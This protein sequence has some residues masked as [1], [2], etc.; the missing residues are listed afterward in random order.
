MD[1]A[2]RQDTESDNSGWVNDNSADPEYPGSR[3]NNTGQMWD[4]HRKF[5]DALLSYLQYG[6]GRSRSYYC[7]CSGAMA[8]WRRSIGLTIPNSVKYKRSYVQLSSLTQHCNAKN[9]VY[10]WGF[11]EHTKAMIENKR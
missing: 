2:M 1:S 5:L 6:G 11:K 9:D 10:H 3:T 7:P 4:E 8:E